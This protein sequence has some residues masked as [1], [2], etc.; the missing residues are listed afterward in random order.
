MVGLDVEDEETG[1]SDEANKG[2]KPISRED[3][4]HR[5]DMLEDGLRLMP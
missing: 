3:R 5:E 2:S 1:S 4:K